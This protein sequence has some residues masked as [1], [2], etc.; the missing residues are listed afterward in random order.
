MRAYYRER[1]PVYD[2]VYAY[3]ERQ[4]DLRWLEA[5]IPAALADRVVLEIAAG[6]GYWTQCISLRA[7]SICATD[8]ALEALR[9]VPARPL[10]CPVE[11]RVAGAYGLNDV[12]GRFSGAFAR[13]WF[14]HIP[15]ARRADWFRALHACLAPG[16][17]VVIVDN[18][19]AQCRRLPIA[20]TD[21]AEN[22]YQLRETDAGKEYEVLKNFPV[23]SELEAVVRQAA[24]P[25]SSRFVELEHYWF[26]SYA[27][28][29]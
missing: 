8:T 2:R 20:R 14:S 11:T 1:A 28:G 13:L 3:P 4:D 15:I 9:Q 27:L 12:G 18:S 19:A 22:T 23:A 17:S 5:A 29:G 16:A 7:T 24:R 6:T 21:Q 10:A 26:F 25:G